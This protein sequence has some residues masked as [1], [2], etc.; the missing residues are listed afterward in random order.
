MRTA[1]HVPSA[2]ETMHDHKILGFCTAGTSA[3]LW[4]IEELSHRQ[5]KTWQIWLAR[6]LWL[7]VVA[8]VFA[9]AD[10]GGDLVYQY[11]VGVA[12]SPHL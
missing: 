11:G 6:A 2:W 10:A 9:T 8:L 7:A 5:Q 3:A 4:I 1:P 12:T